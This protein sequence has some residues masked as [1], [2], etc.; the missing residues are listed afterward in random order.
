MKKFEISLHDSIL[1]LRKPGLEPF[2]FMDVKNTF[3]RKSKTVFKD[4]IFYSLKFI[5]AKSFEEIL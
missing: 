5:K 2:A 1:V 3:L 4:R